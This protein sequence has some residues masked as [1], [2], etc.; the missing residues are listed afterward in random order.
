MFG[1]QPQGGVGQNRAP[2]IK[3]DHCGQVNMSQ[4]MI[5]TSNRG[6]AGL[7][8]FNVKRQIG[9]NVPQ[10]CPSCDEEPPSRILLPCNHAVCM[11]CAPKPKMKRK[12]CP[13]CASG[14]S[15][16]TSISDA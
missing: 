11:D 14:V 15:S 8:Q 7:S 2:F 13:E 4:S 16:I 5:V 1:S 12:V 10:L 3:T 6:D 9:Q